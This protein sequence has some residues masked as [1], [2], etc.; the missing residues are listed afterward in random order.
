[1]TKWLIG[2]SGSMKMDGCGGLTLA[3]CQVPTQPLYH[4]P[5]YPDRGTPDTRG[6]SQESI[7]APVLINT[8]INDL[9]GK[10]ESILSK[11]ADDTKVGVSKIP[12]SHAAIQRDL[13]NL[14]KGINIILTELSQ[15]K[16]KVLHLEG[17]I[18]CTGKWKYATNLVTSARI[19]SKTPTLVCNKWSP[20]TADEGQ[21]LELKIFVGSFQL[22]IFY[23]SVRCFWTAVDV[24]SKVILAQ[25]PQKT[26]EKTEQE[27]HH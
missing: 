14:E 2:L 27:Q 20:Q 26:V 17:A 4:S 22:S 16:H 8:F 9:D 19:L 25:T 15:G 6:V 11:F 12:E 3:G 7:L 13:N 21:E 23:D 24:E 18:P 1:M 5:S 10:A